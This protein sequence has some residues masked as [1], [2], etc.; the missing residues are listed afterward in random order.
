M[1]TGDCV[2]CHVDC[3]CFA[4][5]DNRAWGIPATVADRTGMSALPATIKDNITLDPPLP[6]DF[7]TVRA[8]HKSAPIASA[9]CADGQEIFAY[10][11][12]SRYFMCKQDFGQMLK[13]CSFA[14][15]LIAGGFCGHTK[16]SNS[17]SPRDRCTGGKS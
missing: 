5:Y 11:R 7:R 16:K 13:N 14:V 10:R 9:H 4:N 3:C 8:Q 2:T 6:I 1:C 17:M 12:T 15:V